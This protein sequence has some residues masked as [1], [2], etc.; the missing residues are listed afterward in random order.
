MRFGLQATLS[1]LQHGFS[2]FSG[3]PREPGQ[4]I[5]DPRAAFKIFEQRFDGDSRTA[6]YPGAANPVRIRARQ[7]GKRTNLTWLEV[8]PD[9]AP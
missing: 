5:V 2:H 7:R 8:S 3:N 9:F 1:V 6:K 4:E